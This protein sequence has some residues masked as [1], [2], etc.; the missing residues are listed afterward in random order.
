MKTTIL[1]LDL[2]TTTGCSSNSVKQLKT[3]Q[4]IE[5]DMS[6]SS[7]LWREVVGWPEY[8]VSNLG[9]VRREKPS[10]GTR[11]GKLC[12]PLINRSTGYYGVALCRNCVQK[13]IDIH[14]LVALAFLGPQPSPRH[15]VAHNDG[16]RTNNIVSNLRWATQSENLAD[17]R[18]HG[19]ALVGMANPMAKLDEIDISAIHHMKTLGIPRHV[20]S[21]GLGVHKRTIF[22]VLASSVQGAVL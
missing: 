9:N 20:I 17:M 11:Q 6:C 10:C 7:I 4:L 1:A 3:Q 14:R 19:T 12:K 5:T 21:S 2:G 16:V 22:K 8:Q 13:R 15:L 18:R